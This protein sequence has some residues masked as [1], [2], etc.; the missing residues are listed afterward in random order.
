MKKKTL[1]RIG[2][3]LLVLIGLVFVFAKV[4]RITPLAWGHKEVNKPMF[5]DEAINGYDPVSY[6]TA[7]K[8]VNGSKTFT[9]SWNNATWYFSSRENLE[10]FKSNPER[11]APQFG[12][13][14]AF[15]VSKGFTANTDPNAF[16]IIND[17]LYLCADKKVLEK[18]VAG[19]EENLKKSEENWK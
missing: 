4:K 11:Y 10:L 7:G 18:W 12:G 3:A 19:G 13:F 8:A 14:C 17:K 5:S 1:K 15:A 16:K 6:F 2:I 9:Q